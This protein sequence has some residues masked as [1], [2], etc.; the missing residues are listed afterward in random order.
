MGN[1]LESTEAIH[2]DF[3]RV[4]ILADFPK[5]NHSRREIKEAGRVLAGDI[6]LEDVGPDV[7][8]AF[9]IAHNWRVSHGYPLIRERIRLSRLSSD[10]EG[11]VTAGRI[12]AMA[13]IRNKLK[14]SPIDLRSIQDFAG[15]RAVL[16]DMQAVEAVKAR[17]LEA[18]I[19]DQIQKTNDYIARPKPGG[20]RSFHLVKKFAEA[21][22]GQHYHGQKVEIQLRTRMQHVWATATE[23]VGAMRGEDM[24]GGQGCPDWL[25]LMELMS[26]IIARHEGLPRS[27]HVPATDAG[28]EAEIKD[29][30]AKLDAVAVLRTYRDAVKL[31]ESRAMMNSSYFVLTLDPD[32]GEVSIAPQ[33]SF[34]AGAKSY[35]RAIQPSGKAQ[36][37]LVSVDSVDQ[38]RAAYPNYFLDVGD[39]LDLLEGVC[40]KMRPVRTFKNLDLSFLD[41][42]G[43]RQ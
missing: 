14:R 42:Y 22:M 12:K 36:H 27:E 41:N 20:Y 23:A 37:V 43:K 6:S 40:G 10:F 11:R 9:Q 28:L 2:A 13:S 34:L 31:S 26:A 32:K 3:E 29:L 7:V 8:A 15:I 25:R 21:G 39:F 35:G 18:G 1:I 19:A 33:Q 4:D 38:L 16:P 24:K 5:N 17:Y 30:D